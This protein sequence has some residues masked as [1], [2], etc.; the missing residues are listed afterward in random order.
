MEVK[1]AMILLLVHHPNLQVL[2]FRLRYTYIPGAIFPT[3]PLILSFHLT[4]FRSVYLNSY[5]IQA[6]FFS[7]SF[8]LM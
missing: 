3:D 8:T 7:I 5:T 1:L 6:I 2:I 4:R